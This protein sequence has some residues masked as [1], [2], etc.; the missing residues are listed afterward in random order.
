MKPPPP[1]GL[2]NRSG[3][4]ESSIASSS[5]SSGSFAPRLR[6]T[7]AG[8][9]RSC[10]AAREHNARIFAARITPNSGAGSSIAA[11]SPAI[12]NEAAG[13]PLRPAMSRLPIDAKLPGS[14]PLL[15]STA[16]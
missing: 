3:S 5:N 11:R 4:S 10:P 14:T 9:S 16:R 8:F 13:E 15:A 12:L 6:G 1:T 7:C 2:L